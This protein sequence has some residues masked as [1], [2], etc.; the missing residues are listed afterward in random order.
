VIPP[1]RERKQDMPALVHYLMTKKSK[2]L[3][4][5]GEPSLAPGSLDRLT[6]YHWPGN[7]RE[8]ENVLERALILANGKPLAFDRFALVPDDG[9]RRTAADGG[10]MDLNR[11]TA[12]HI[13]EVLS[14]TGGKVHGPGGAAEVLKI[15]PSTLRHKMRTLGIP[16]GRKAKRQ[17]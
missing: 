6:A 2:Q 5:H 17:S 15:N 14:I 11:L 7:V 8:L 9:D 12:C 13:R 16:F 3:R 4:F 10:S 1:L